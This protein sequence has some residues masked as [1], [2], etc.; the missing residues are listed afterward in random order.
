MP[1]SPVSSSCM[2]RRPT[3]STSAGTTRSAP[4]AASPRP[5]SPYCSCRQRCSRWRCCSWSRGCSRRVRWPAKAPKASGGQAAAA[6]RARRGLYRGRRPRDVGARELGVGRLRRLRDDGPLRVHPSWQR[7]DVVC[8]RAARLLGD[9]RG[10]AA[11][12][13]GAVRRRSAAAAASS[14]DGR[15]G[16]RSGD[17]R[18]AVSVAVCRRH[19]PGAELVGVAANGS[20][21]RLRR[22][23]GGTRLA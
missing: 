19:A 13:P 23:R 20:S 2:W 8:R 3:S 5:F 21:V 12:P 18:G 15:S 9:V 1:S 17:V 10:V 22:P 4:Q 11:V 6:R 7:A 14:R 16:H